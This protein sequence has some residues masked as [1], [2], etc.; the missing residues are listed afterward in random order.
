MP[1]LDLE[2]WVEKEMIYVDDGNIVT[3]AVEP[4]L[5][6][7]DGKVSILPGAVTEDQDVPA[8]ERTAKFVKSVSNSIAPMIRMEEEYPSNHPAGRMPILDLE[9]WV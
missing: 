6:F 4:G 3:E 1:I 8:D 2:V 9:V 7:T 5:R